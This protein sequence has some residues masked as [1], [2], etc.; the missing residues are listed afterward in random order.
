MMNLE[1]LKNNKTYQVIGGVIAGYVVVFLVFYF[2]GIAPK[3]AKVKELRAKAAEKQSFLAKA[4]SVEKQKKKI[5]DAKLKIA[6]LKQNISYYE[7]K[8][9]TEK[10]IPDLLQYLSNIAIETDVTLLEI[11]K[12]QEIREEKDQTFYVTVPFNLI[13]RGGYHNIGAFINKLENADRFMKIDQFEIKGDKRDPFE[14]RG[15]MMV[16]TYI[17]DIQEPAQD[18]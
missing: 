18:E 17:L 3:S 10:D 16:Y 5:E 2:A 1:D 8:L 6:D 11:E 9:P 14:H 15:E 4:G 7:K 12:K 13:L